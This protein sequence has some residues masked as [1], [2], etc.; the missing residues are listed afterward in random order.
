MAIHAC[1]SKQLIC[2]DQQYIDF[3][4]ENGI[5]NKTVNIT[6]L[7]GTDSC[8]FLIRSECGAPAFSV[9]PGN[10]E[11]TANVKI[12]VAE[13]DSNEV[14]VSNWTVTTNNNYTAWPNQ[15]TTTFNFDDQS[16][17]QGGTLGPRKQIL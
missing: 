10:T 4:T 9:A 15:T 17:Y 12:A 11:T 1:P 14:T 8:T 5:T 2:G 6:S 7:T 16:I 13:W 3:T